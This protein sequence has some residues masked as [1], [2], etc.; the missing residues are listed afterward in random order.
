MFDYVKSNPSDR[1]LCGGIHSYVT[2]AIKPIV[3]D[4]PQ[5]KL[6]IFGDKVRGQMQRVAAKNIELVFT[7]VGKKVCVS[8]KRHCSSCSLIMMGIMRWTQTTERKYYHFDLCFLYLSLL[9]HYN[10]LATCIRRGCPR[11]TRSA[12]YGMG[13]GSSRVQQIRLGHCIQY[14]HRNDCFTKSYG[15]IRYS[16]RCAFLLFLSCMDVFCYMHL[17]FCL[18]DY[19]ANY[20]LFFRLTKS[21]FFFVA[22]Y[23]GIWQVRSWRRSP[24]VIRRIPTGC[25]FVWMHARKCGK[26][27]KCSYAGYGERYQECRYEYLAECVKSS[28]LPDDVNCCCFLCVCVCACVGEMIDKLRLAYNRTR[29]AVITNELIEIISGA[30][31]V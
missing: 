27:T 25:Y 30:S 1:G 19:A 13:Y 26:W 7:E 11:C 14:Y 24:S 4:D 31:A 15:I 2:K 18:F 5:A 10:V 28:F 9:F 20:C 12:W 16:A 3:A 22:I 8:I 21:Y 29:Q 23:R 6:V 17:L